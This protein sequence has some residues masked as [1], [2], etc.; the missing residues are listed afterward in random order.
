[1]IRLNRWWLRVVALF[2]VAHASEA[3]QIRSD[4]GCKKDM[5]GHHIVYKDSLGKLTGGYGHLLEGSW[6]KEGEAI[7]QAIVDRGFKEDLQTGD[8]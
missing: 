8:L 6:L 7:P 4:E 1:M 2:S 3:S 5:Q